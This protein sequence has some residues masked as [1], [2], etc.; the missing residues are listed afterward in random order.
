MKIV[1]LVVLVF[2]INSNAQNLKEILESLNKS[3]KIGAIEAKRDADIAQSALI[4]TYNSPSIGAS[5]SHAKETNRDGLEYSFGVTQ[6]I[7]SPFTSNDKN[8]ASSFSSKAL[9]QEAKHQLHLMRLDV[10]SSYYSACVAKELELASTELYTQENKRIAQ[11]KRAYEVG[12]VSRKE[13]LFNELELAKL[14]RKVQT[15]KRVYTDEF[16]SLQ[17]QLDTLELE[18]LSCSDLNAPNKDI[19]LKDI[20]TNAE[21]QALTYKIGASKALYGVNNSL[22][23]SISYELLYEKELD[24]KRYTFGLSIPIGSFTDKQELL[25]KQA[26]LEKTS[27][28]F[29]HEFAKNKIQKASEGLLLKVETLYDEYELLKERILP[30]SEELLALS[31]AAHAEGEG[32]IM[33]YLDASRSYNENRLEMLELKKTY[34]YE[35]FE[36]YKVADMD[37][38]E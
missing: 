33:E 10:S 9:S 29:E 37:Y 5:L 32:T 30:L 22:L 13:L 35:L 27:Y 24:T 28:Q 8:L 38:G 23:N 15:Y 25:Q 18:T 26:L 20:E 7:D 12:E 11:S 2:S 16:M 36:L 17:E 6:E 31:K 14:Y 4:S 3:S 34:Y 1:L 21:L 19:V